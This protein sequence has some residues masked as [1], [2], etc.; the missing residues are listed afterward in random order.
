VTATG[1][2]GALLAL[3]LLWGCAA[4][5]PAADAGGAGGDTPAAPITADAATTEGRAAIVDAVLGILAENYAAGTHGSDPR[6][7][8]AGARQDLVQAPDAEAFYQALNESLRTAG[9]THLYAYRPGRDLYDRDSRETRLVGASLRDVGGYLFVADVWEGGPAF[10]AG[11]RYG[12]ELLPVDGLP[13]RLDPL[14]AGTDALRLWVRR[15][16]ESEP[17]Y[18]DVTPVG[19]E[20][21]WYLTEA[22]RASIRKLSAGNC[23]VGLIHLR[24]FADEAL[25]DELITGAEFSESD[26]LILDLRGNTGGEIRLAGEVLDLLTR[27][28]SIWITYRDRPYP[29][30]ATT[31]NLPLMVLVDENTRSAAEI[32][33][34]AVQARGLGTVVGIPTPGQVQG[35]RLFPLPDGAR[36]LVPVSD[37]ILPDGDSLEGRG[38][39]PDEIVDRPIMYAAGLDP[40][41]D[42]AVELLQDQLACPEDLPPETFPHETLP[43]NNGPAEAGS[44]GSPMP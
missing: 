27:E 4:R 44:G 5:G 30:P 2:V 16:R 19:G 43:G 29:F 41:L 8:L 13:A 7:T 14:P 15:S 18:M 20:T 26:G 38:V 36:L 21:I 1:R 28:P 35:S 23:R 25:V 40:Q 32:F 6:L 22:T 17:V 42:R 37:V 31:W 10:Q 9:S 34:A 11:L 33:A 39:I 24:T 12:D 3:S